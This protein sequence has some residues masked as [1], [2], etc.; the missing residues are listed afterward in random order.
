YE[1]VIYFATSKTIHD[2]IHYANLAKTIINDPNFII[3]DTKTFGPGVHQILEILNDLIEEG[4][5]PSL[6]QKRLEYI[7]EH[8]IL[9]IA[10][11]K[12]YLSF[13]ESNKKIRSS[14]VKIMNFTYILSFKQDKFHV[15]KKILRKLKVDS[16]L[17]SKVKELM[18]FD[19]I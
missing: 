14:I 16:Y 12:P 4:P 5:S 15:E 6:I 18:P 3:V 2:G 17:C 8:G 19:E 9:Y 13:L 10:T 11:Q 7:I 1:K